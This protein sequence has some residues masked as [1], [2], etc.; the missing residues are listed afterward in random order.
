MICE[1]AEIMC[2]TMRAILTR[3]A[4][5]LSTVRFTLGD[6]KN[7]LRCQ[8]LWPTIRFKVL[9]YFQDPLTRTDDWK[10]HT[11]TLA[12]YS[13]TIRDLLGGLSFSVSQEEVEAEQDVDYVPPLPRMLTKK[14]K[15]ERKVRLSCGV[16]ALISCKAAMLI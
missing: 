15:V 3:F 5:K 1:M 2:T 12:V 4:S 16:K 14:E 10:D 13:S 8:D 11:V 6:L 7:S 9:Q